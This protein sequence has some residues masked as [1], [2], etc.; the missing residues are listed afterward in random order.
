MT[1]RKRRSFL[2]DRPPEVRWKPYIYRTGHGKWRVCLGDWQDGEYRDYSKFSNA[3]MTANTWAG[4]EGSVQNQGSLRASVSVSTLEVALT[5]SLA[6]ARPSEAPQ[7]LR[8]QWCYDILQHAPHSDH[9]SGTWCPG[10]DAQLA[11]AA[12][13]VRSLDLP[14]SRD[15]DPAPDPVDNG[16]HW[17]STSVTGKDL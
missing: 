17:T 12:R 3:I 13:G 5:P 14:S 4:R 10:T 16:A 11:A 2:A 1:R 7:G 15:P 9:D 6:P 8:E